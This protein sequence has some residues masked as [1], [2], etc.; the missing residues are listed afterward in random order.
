MSEEE[1][2]AKARTLAKRIDECP[3]DDF[4]QMRQLLDEVEEVR[5]AFVKLQGLND[6]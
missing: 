2:D 1:F 3:I 6:E 5:L 4:E